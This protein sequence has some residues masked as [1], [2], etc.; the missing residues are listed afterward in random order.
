MKMTIIRVLGIVSLFA[1]LSGLAICFC[2]PI[3]ATFL[4]GSCLGVCSAVC[5]IIGL[6]EY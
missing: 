3:W 1:V 5:F 6:E 2:T 4:N